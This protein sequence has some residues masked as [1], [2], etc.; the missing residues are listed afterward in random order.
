MFSASK[1]PQ[2]LKPSGWLAMLPP[3]VEKPP[4]QDE[5]TADIA[6]IGGGFAG[7]AAARRLSQIDPKLKVAIFEALA[8]GEGACGRNSG[9]IIDLPHEV[10][11]ESYGSDSTGAARR[12]IAMNRTAIALARGM[13]EEQGWG[14]DIF[15]P[16]GKYSVA[17]GG[18][19]GHHLASYAKQLAGFNE[20]H[21][22]MNASEIQAVTGS[23]AFTSG[24]FTPGCVIIQPA[25]YAR[26]FAD[27][28]K[29]PLRIY[30]RTPVLS[31][32]RVSSGW[33]L[34][35]PKGSVDAGKIILANN[36]HAQSFG[37]F[38]GQ[39]LHIFTY[40]SLTEEF[41]PGRV[42]GERQWAATPAHPMGTSVR[43]VRGAEGDRILIRSRYTYQPS[44]EVTE[45][46]IASAGRLHDRKFA[47][48]FPMLRN[49]G[50]QYRWGGAMALTWNAVPAFGE[51][52]PGLIAACACN[53]VGATK[54]SAAGI[55]AA[56]LALGGQ[57]ELLSIIS[58]MA[59][60]RPLPPQPLTTIGVKASLALRHWRAGNE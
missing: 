9:F 60:P 50:M 53:G 25:A 55:A 15:D 43:R 3:R 58:S 49:V 51:L 42:T 24:L 33:R 37:F 23:P 2:Q 32:E 13:A 14:R 19:G 22:L 45:A 28:L 20:P 56:D 57:S 10:S 1:L 39:L 44:L 59:A 7:L 34:E 36:G 5:E 18:E 29:P 52:E 35:T 40:A 6:I 4:L 48:R 31:F 46:E 41:D 26:A 30:E 16:C 47:A 11:S 17:M 38:R 21:R 27:A 54:A 8:I 12:E